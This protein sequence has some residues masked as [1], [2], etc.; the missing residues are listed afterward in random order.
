MTTLIVGTLLFFGVHS[1]SIVSPGWRNGIASRIGDIRW[2]LIYSVAS[3]LGFTLI[4]T[5]YAALRLEPRIVYLPPAGLRH[6]ATLLMLPVFPLLLA[7][8]LPGRLQRAAKHPMLVAVK[9][10]ALAHLLANGMLAD[11]LL[12]GSFLVWAV[13]DRI[14]LKRRPERTRPMAPAG[15]INDVIAV[16]GGITLYGAFVMGWHQRLFGVAPFG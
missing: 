13:V 14:S 5:G 16:L 8:Y 10:W 1:V 6:V 11:V 2:K 7:T 4:I 9:F 12:F 3:I 15:A